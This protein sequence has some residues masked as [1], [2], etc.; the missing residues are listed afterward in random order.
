MNGEI[1]SYITTG[2]LVAFCLGITRLMMIHTNGVNKKIDNIEDKTVTKE[3]CNATV[4]RIEQATDRT[5]KNIEKIFNLLD[6]R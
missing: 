5:E 2:S 3:L 1:V 4:K 6:K